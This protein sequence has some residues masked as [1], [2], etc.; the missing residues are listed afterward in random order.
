M[1]NKID[2]VYGTLLF[3]SPF[4]CNVIKPSMNGQRKAR[5]VQDTGS[6]SDHCLSV[7]PVANSNVASTASGSPIL[8]CGTCA[9][10]RL[11]VARGLFMPGLRLWR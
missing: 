1:V 9:A 5:L 7:R 11:L 4:S 6:G 3:S 8:H 10:L 2:Y